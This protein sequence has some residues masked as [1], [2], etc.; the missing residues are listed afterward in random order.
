MSGDRGG[1]GI[2][3]VYADIIVGFYREG[4]TPRA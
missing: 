2:L 1:A 3:S 4:H